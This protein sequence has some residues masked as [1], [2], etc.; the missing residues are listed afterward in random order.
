L[1]KKT[2]QLNNLL[3]PT[4]E[5]P[6]VLE[7]LAVPP[8]DIA[9][10]YFLNLESLPENE[11]RTLPLYIDPD[12]GGKYGIESVK[13]G[14][15]QKSSGKTSTRSGYGTNNSNSSGKSSTSSGKSIT[16]SGYETNNSKQSIEKNQSI[17]SGYGTTHSNSNSTSSINNNRNSMSSINNNGNSHDPIFRMNN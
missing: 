17:E 3:P 16:N 10:S 7:Q 5:Q 4:V 2:L 8:Y 15:T 11:S 13:I 1:A 14:R 12:L 9:K 6:T